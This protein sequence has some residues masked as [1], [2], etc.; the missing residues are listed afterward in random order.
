MSAVVHVPDVD[1]P[2]LC[3]AMVD[4]KPGEP[5]TKIQMLRCT[6]KKGHQGWH[7]WQKALQ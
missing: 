1:H 5:R 7:S 3:Y 4:V 6:L 2:T